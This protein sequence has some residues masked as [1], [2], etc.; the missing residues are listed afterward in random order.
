M[1]ATK[2][3]PVFAVCSIVPF[4]MFASI[5]ALAEEKNDDPGIVKGA[6]KGSVAG[7]IIPGVSAET[8]AK[9]GATVGGV[10]KLKQNNDEKDDND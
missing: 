9:V 2:F 8:G 1:N 6:V 10:K 4:V 7:A 5:S 3:A